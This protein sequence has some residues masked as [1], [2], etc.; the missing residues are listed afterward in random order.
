M[1]VSEKYFVLAATLTIIASISFLQSSISA[2][3]ATPE[4]SFEQHLRDLP[5]QIIAP[6]AIGTTK[7]QMFVDTGAGSSALDLSIAKESVTRREGVDLIDPNGGAT[8]AQSVNTLPWRMQSLVMEEPRVTLV[9]LS[10][11][12]SAVGG[13][14]LGVLGVPQIQVG[15]LLLDYDSKLLAIHGGNWRLEG[16][17]VIRGQLDDTSEVP[18]FRAEIEGKKFDLAIDTGDDG[19]VA[20]D[21]TTFAGFVKLGVIEPAPIRGRMDVLSGSPGARYGWFLKGELM[22]RPLRGVTVLAHEGLMGTGA[23]GLTWLYAF[24]VEIDF[25]AKQWRYRK[26]PNVTPPVSMDLMIGAMFSFDQK[27]TR[28]TSLRPVV[29]AAERSGLRVG[30]VI[31]ECDSL[32]GAEID[33][34][35]LSEVVKSKAGSSVAIKYRRGAEEFS[36]EI[37]L[38]KG[39][40]A[41]DFAGKDTFKGNSDSNGSNP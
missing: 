27:G 2:G 9:D 1:L 15:K 30:D 39:I 22:G 16:A 19:S 32:K 18:T 20:L 31:E 11:L 10:G 3:E 23:I 7:Y 26:R 25:K 40:S 13:R 35:S 29:G 4:M 24:S 21:Q 34:A 41:W 8:Q 14:I 12:G 33:K 28:I 5:T 36:G 37:V 38:P 6:V 17:D